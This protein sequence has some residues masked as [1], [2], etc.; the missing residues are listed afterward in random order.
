MGLRLLALHGPDRPVPGFG[1]D[2]EIRVECRTHLDSRWYA[3]AGIYRDVHLV[4]KRTGAFRARRRAG[5][6]SRRRRRS[7]G[8]RGRGRRRERRRRS[9]RP[10]RARRAPSSTRTA[11]TVA[12]ATSPVTLLPG[13]QRHRAAPA[14]RAGP[15]AVERRLPAPVR[16]RRRA[17]RR[18]RRARLDGETRSTFGIRTLQLDPVR[19]P[20]DQRRAG[21]AARRLHPPRQRPPRRRL[22]AAAPRSAG[23]AAQGGRLQRDPQRTQPDEP[24]PARRLRPLGMLVMDEAFDMWTSG[25]SDFDY[26]L[27]FPQWWERDVEAMVAK[28]LN[29]P[30]VIFYSI[31]NEI[32]ETGT[33]HRRDLGPP[34][35]REGPLARRTRFVTNGINGFVSMLDTILPQMQ[36]RRAAA[37]AARRTER[38]RRRQHDDGR[39]RPDDGP[40]SRPPSAATEAHR[41]VVRRARRRR[42]QLRRRPLRA[43]T[44]SRSPTGSSSAPRPSRRRSTGNWALVTANPHVIGDFTW[45]GW[46]YLGEAGI[47]AIRYAGRDGGEPAHRSPAVTRGSPPGAATSTSPATAGPSPTT[48]R[49]SSGCAE[50]VHRRPP[51]RA[52]TA[53]QV[54]VATPWAWSDTVRE[55]DLAGFEGR[56][57]TVEVYSDAEEVELLLDGTSRRPGRGRRRT[58]L[59]RR[60]RDRLPARRT[61]RRRLH[62]RRRD[63][64]DVA[65]IGCRSSPALLGRR[66]DR[67][68]RRRVRPCRVR[69]HR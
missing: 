52:V 47:G 49:S 35:G 15:A 68:A 8:G 44:G 9:R 51:A 2:N 14:V 36:Q 40:A 22:D 41:G 59:P 69:A 4:V 54:A 12:T 42:H 67:G 6:H 53:G 39:V 57:V 46:D 25:K 33:P 19:R 7:R 17:E 23:S 34:P 37:G 24:R 20:A 50:P 60:V 66:T 3:G 1:A 16:R 27:D 5:H 62:R 48:A 32:P 45:T 65:P 58:A 63:R 18:R 29:H 10:S 28:D 31:G 13:D 55:L 11:S 26:A 38:R 21:E 64:P 43:R 61:D 30:S 56:A